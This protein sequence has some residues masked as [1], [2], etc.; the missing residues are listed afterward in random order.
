MG[1]ILWLAVGERKLFGVWL[2]RRRRVAFVLHYIG[3]QT[4]W[5]EIRKPFQDV[6]RSKETLRFHMPRANVCKRQAARLNTTHL[7]QREPETLTTP[8]EFRRY[9]KGQRLSNVTTKSAT[10]TLHSKF[11]TAGKGKTNQNCI[12][13]EA[14][15]SLNWGNV[16]QQSVCNLPSSSW[17]LTNKNIKLYKTTILAV[18]LYGC[19]TWPLI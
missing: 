11:Q 10:Q 8:F 9:P 5:R 17:L 19:E 15:C 6:E 16:S 4:C 14:E 13:E 2:L 12:Q 1:W 7:L 18:V 3:F